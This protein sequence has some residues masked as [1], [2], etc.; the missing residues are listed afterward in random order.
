MPNFNHLLPRANSIVFVDYKPA[1]LRINK[2]WLI[3][4]YAK[5][6]MT[7]KMERF[8]MR[9]PV[10]KNKS[11]RTRHANRIVTEI[12]K[13][14]ASGWSPWLE[15]P[16]KSF[17]AFEEG[18][19]RFLDNTEKEIGDGIKRPDTL[20]AYKSYLN[21]IKTYLKEKA[22]KITF[23]IEFNKDVAIG[24]L[25]WIYYERQNSPNTY[26]NHL[27]F[28]C[29]FGNFLIE[30]G[31][32]KE[33]PTNEISKKR[34][35]LK[36]RKVIDPHIKTLLSEKLPLFNF[37]YYALCMVTYYCMVRRTEITKL[38]VSDFNL[39]E[40]YI[41]IP[42]TVS[43]NRKDEYVTIPKELKEILKKHFEGAQH[44]NFAFSAND[45]KAGKHQL[46]PKRIS[47]SWV[48]VRKHLGLSTQFQFYSL[49]DTGITD[50]FGLGISPLK[51]RD[52]ARHYDLKIT[53]LYT[54]RSGGG[55]ESLKN[56]GAKF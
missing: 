41:T 13:K 32:I 27:Q 5:N 15:T 53:E 50:L 51:I 4:Y 6:P 47:D 42:G 24:Y 37:N 54:P 23:A 39:V 44:N 14:L 56:S 30:R 40:D 9:V 2:D 31:Y 19:N 48:Q 3:I 33:N 26:N 12:N 21:M 46:P 7:E 28:L 45:F 10:L 16:G 52:Q 43:K 55:D 22:I 17:K 36:K 11:E 1:E 35:Q 20:R 18:C 8:R 29:T 38:K 34:K 49:K 25:D